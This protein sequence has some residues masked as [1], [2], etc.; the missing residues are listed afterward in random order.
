MLR[1][2]GFTEQWVHLVMTY[3]TTVTYSL[4]VYSSPCV[5]L[6][7]S[8]GLRQRDLLSPYLF[9][10]CVQ[11]FSSFLSQVE[12]IERLQ[13][14]SICRGAPPITHLLFV[15]DCYLF[16]R[17]NVEKCRTI[18]EALS[19]YEGV[20]GQQD[21]QK[22]IICFSKN[23]MTQA[24]MDL[25]AMLGVPCIEQYDKYLRLPIAVGKNKGASF[26]HLNER[27]GKKL[28]SWKRKLLSGAGKEIIIKTVAQAIPLYSMIC[29]L[30]PKYLCEDLDRLIAEFWWDGDDGERKIHWL[31][32]DKL[33]KPK[34][35]GD[36]FS[37]SVC[38]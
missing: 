31:A 33:C 12:R 5:Y 20:S 1:R 17:A 18:N 38:F 15:D 37:R 32:W 6:T 26:V 24:Q 25:A 16:A 7:P 36:G 11:G 28:L 22:S 34:E 21:L 19:W 35:L 30:L 10:L 23:V 29:Y 14:V 9:I 8:R 4:L 27:L 3:V 13:G 2:L